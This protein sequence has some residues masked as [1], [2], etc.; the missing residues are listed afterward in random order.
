[1]SIT[2]HVTAFGVWS[3]VV[4]SCKAVG[5]GPVGPI[6]AGPTFSDWSL[7]GVVICDQVIL[8]GVVICYWPAPRAHQCSMRIR[9]SYRTSNSCNKQ[10]SESSN[11]RLNPRLEGKQ[12]SIIIIIIIM[13]VNVDD[14]VVPMKPISHSHFQTC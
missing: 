8:V 12:Q 10:V 11:T 3:M 5:S 7:V 1:M 4:I 9:S 2:S 6:W 14:T 13:A